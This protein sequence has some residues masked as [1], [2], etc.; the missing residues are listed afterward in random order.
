[1]GL[2]VKSSRNVAVENGRSCRF[3][4]CWMMVD[5]CI[6]SICKGYLAL[7]HVLF[8]FIFISILFSSTNYF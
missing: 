8:L 5:S 3:L 4:I 2:R 7:A 1:M 6:R